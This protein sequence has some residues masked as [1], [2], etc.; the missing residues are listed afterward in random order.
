M[1]KKQKIM[2]IISSIICFIILI[3]LAISY[4]YFTTNI[5]GNESSTTISTSGGTLSIEVSGGN[6]F[7]A[8]NLYPKAIPIV[9]KT[10]TIIG[11]NTTDTIMNYELNLVITSNTFTTGAL[12]YSLAGT[13]TSGSGAIVQNINN[14]SLDNGIKTYSLGN[15]SFKT[16]KNKVHTYKLS[17]YFLDTGVDQSIDMK[18]NFAGHIEVTGGNLVPQVPVLLSSLILGTDNSNVTSTLTIPGETVSSPSESVLASTPDDYGTSYYYRGVIENNYVVFANMCWRIV[19][20]TGNGAIK[21]ALYNRNIDKVSNPCDSSLDGPFNNLIEYDKSFKSLEIEDATQYPNYSDY[22][23]NFFPFLP[24]MEQTIDN[25]FIGLMYGNGFGYYGTEVKRMFENYNM[26]SQPNKADYYYGSNYSY[27]SSTNLFSLSGNIATKNWVND[28]DDIIANYKYSCFSTDANGTCKWLN[29]ISKYV[30]NSL[31]G[32]YSLSTYVSSTSYIQAHA[33]INKSFQLKLLEAWYN[34]RLTNYSDKLADVIWCNDKSL[35]TII[36]PPD[37]TETKS[38]GYGNNFSN[39]QASQRTTPTLICP[40]DENG[41]KLSK[42][43]V[44]DTLHGNGDL[45][46]PIGLLTADEFLF[47]GMKIESSGNSDNSNSN[48]FLFKNTKETM[49]LTLSP[50]EYSNIVFLSSSYNGSVISVFAGLELPGFQPSIALKSN[51]MVIGI[52]TQD[53]PYIVK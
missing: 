14:A 41:G 31:A 2:I 26:T 28:H 20:I 23:S 9:I 52:G 45:D 13:I 51:V 49:T 16:G 50:F 42:F 29:E 5:S 44:D 27:D 7:S 38:L 1:Q 35:G 34:L 48:T 8:S 36:A 32:F 39:Y 3:I 43:T 53:S 37:F 15:G 6:S 17:F 10:F 12:T 40:N 19:R 47:S 22:S 24:P 11:T 21:L 30:N 4:G 33:N 46:Y 18:K 25:A